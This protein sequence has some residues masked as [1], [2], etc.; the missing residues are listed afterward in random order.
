MILSPFAMLDVHDV[1][2]MRFEKGCKPFRLRCRRKNI[3]TQQVRLLFD[4]DKPFSE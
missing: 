2:T 3:I 1:Q 4:S